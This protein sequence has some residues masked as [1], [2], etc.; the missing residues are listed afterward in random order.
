MNNYYVYLHIKGT[1]GEPFYVGKGKGYRATSKSKRSNIWNNYFKKYGFDVIMLEECL[2]EDEAF[3]REI[4][5]INRIGRKTKGNGPLVNLECGGKGFS[6]INKGNNF[7]NKKVI[8]D[9]VEY[10]SL[11]EASD[12]LK[13][14]YNTLAKRI[15]IHND[16]VIVNA[17]GNRNHKSKLVIDTKTNII[18]DSLNIAIK[19]LNLNYKYNTLR[20]QISGQTKINK[21]TLKYLYHV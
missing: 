16:N 18:Y 15:R 13:I 19:E 20:A 3:E 1:N 17:S 9:G 14:N 4:Y 12:K 10:N 8:I 5:W 7:R 21:T 11:I 2:T 6:N